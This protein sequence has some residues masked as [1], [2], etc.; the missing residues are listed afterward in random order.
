[1]N[2]VAPQRTSFLASLPFVALVALVSCS[3][4]LGD[5]AGVPFGGPSDLPEAGRSDIAP[6]PDGG[7]RRDSG[8][9]PSVEDA[10]EFMCASTPVAYVLETTDPFTNQPSTLAAQLGAAGFEVRPLPLDVNPS[11]LRGLIAFSSFASESPVYKDYVSRNAVALY[12]FVD[13][14]NVL[15]QLTQADQTEPTP[16]FL[17]SNMTAQRQDPDLTRL[18][19]TSGK[20]PL[21]NN[22]PVRQDGAIFWEFPQLGWEPFAAQGGFEVIL[23]S[24]RNSQ[25]PALMEGAYGQGRIVLSALALDKPVGLGPD[26]DAFTTAFFSNLVQHTRRVCERRGAPLRTT[27]SSFSPGFADTSTMLAV[28][29]DTQIYSLLYPGVFTAQTSWI[30]ANTAARQ[31]SYVFHLGDIVDRNTD[32]E[33]SRAL[34]AMNQLDNV[35]PYALATGNHDYGPTGNA[36]TRDTLLNDYFPFDK[37]AAMPSFGGAL[38]PGKL[39]NTYHLVTVGGRNYV[40]L[41]LEWGPRDGV[42]NWANEVMQ[43]YPDRYGILI[44]HAYMNW[45][46]RRYDMSEAGNPANPQDFNPHYYGTAGGVNDGEELWQKLVRKYPFV[47]VFN[48]HVLADGTGYLAS[49]TDRGTICHQMLSNYQFRPRLGGDGYM[50]LLEFLEDQQTV[51]VFTYSPLDDSFL[52]EPDQNY[53]FT[54]DLPAGPGPQPP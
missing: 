10:A 24:T 22:V 19:V 52:T 4:D 49:V 40:L 16:P 2:T 43:K 32:L 38:E 50:R 9:L 27:P 39:D 28:L 7:G 35:V 46:D 47:M 29:P 17:P 54:L 5:R 36:R 12:Q 18:F 26:R 42:I 3:D 21:L 33:W 15:L 30:A 13:K 44:T 41:A 48:G 23:A 37:A 20:N 8:A 45:N 31:I 14:A 51:R 34:T 11:T 53:T 6:R 25:I 1:M